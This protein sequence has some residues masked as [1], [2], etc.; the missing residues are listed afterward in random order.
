MP[1]LQGTAGFI[2]QGHEVNYAALLG[3]VAAGAFT[4]PL[5]ARLAELLGLHRNLGVG[6][7]L[8][9]AAA[10]AAAWYVKSVRGRSAALRRAARARSR[11]TETGGDVQ[12][13][14][15]EAGT[16]T[17]LRTAALPVEEHDAGVQRHR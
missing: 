11:M 9:I 13:V 15:A 1:P 10:T 6:V 4:L 2:W 3:V 5:L 7:S 12:A 17:T 16:E 14:A 8:M